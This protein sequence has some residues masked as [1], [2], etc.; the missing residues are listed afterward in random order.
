MSETTLTLECPHSKTIFLYPEQ[1]GVRLS[2]GTIRDGDPGFKPRHL[3]PKSAASW[4]VQCGALS[5]GKNGKW[6]TPYAYFPG[7]HTVTANAALMGK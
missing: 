5:L 4:C 7:N 1:T 6:R 3:A 2:Y